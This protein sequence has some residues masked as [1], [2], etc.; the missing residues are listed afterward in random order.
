[1]ARVGTC[2]K[3]AANTAATMSGVAT[4]ELEKSS[5]MDPTTVVTSTPHNKKQ[6]NLSR[7]TI[8]TAL[9]ASVFLF[10]LP[11]GMLLPQASAIQM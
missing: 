11:S 2:S 8:V 10:T 9:D 3:A 4:L 5:A 6:P 7:A 1:M